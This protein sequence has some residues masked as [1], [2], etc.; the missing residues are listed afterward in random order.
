MLPLI[1]GGS[2]G[3]W[4]SKVRPNH[5]RAGTAVAVTAWGAF[6]NQFAAGQQ[7]SQRPPGLEPHACAS[8]TRLSLDR[9]FG[10]DRT[11]AGF[12]ISAVGAGT[13]HA[14][15]AAGIEGACGP[16]TAVAGFGL[17]RCYQLG[18][19]DPEQATDGAGVISISGRA[20]QIACGREHSAMIV[21][22]D[23]GS[24]KVMVCGS[25]AFGQLGRVRGDPR[26]MPTLHRS[27]IGELEALD[28]ML[29][30]GEAPTKVQCGLDHTLVLTTKG[31]VF[32]MGWGA[33]GQLGTG[34]T[35]DSD[36]P[37]RVCGLE[38]APV[39]DI[40]ST[41]DFTLALTAD[42]RLLYW[43]NAEY[44]Q[45]MVGRKIDKVLAPM[46]IPFDKGPIRSV[47]A[48]GTHA[49]LLTED[50]RVYACGYGALGLGAGCVSALVP[51]LV[52][53]LDR[54][55]WL[56]A[57]TDRCLAIDSSGRMYSW[58][59]GNSMGR[60]GNGSVSENSLLPSMLDT[61]LGPIDSALV[62]LGNDI[63]IIA[64]HDQTLG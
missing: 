14:M 60:L 9:L 22:Q 5:T 15:I 32:A 53:G 36:K 49:M 23:S 54:I 16:E 38:D 37:V 63:A 31:R 19:A 29:G 43:G 27:G 8:P 58:G 28:G 52:R 1:R 17:N 55:G 2:L 56:A 3:A 39:V 35:M 46:Q 6:V 50:G 20:V 12:H 42:N 25:N 47:A 24:R 33:D 18:N 61:S 57:S 41:T 13:R 21:Q 45:C 64:T 48:G 44:G 11:G 30:S 51:G 4:P 10:K 59:L 62:A 34:S 7:S 26:G 40:S